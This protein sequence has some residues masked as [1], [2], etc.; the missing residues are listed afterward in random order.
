MFQIQGRNPLRSVHDPKTVAIIQARMGSTRLPGKV[1]TEINGQPMLSHV[2]NRVARANLVDEVVAAVPHTSRDKSLVQYCEQNEINV[3]AGSETDVLSRYIKAAT[4]SDAE[5]VVRITADCPLVDPALIDETISVLNR[6]PDVEYASNFWP[7]RNYP[8][9]LDTEVLTVEALLKVDRLSSA[10]NHREHV[11]LG[12][13][14]QPH[15]FKI[16][17]NFSVKDFGHLRWT[18]DTEADLQLVREI[19]RHFGER[20]FGWQDI[21][22]AYREFPHWNSINQHISQKAA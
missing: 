9:G 2:V 12:I 19:Y 1:L 20:E 6:I 16:G 15:L 14:Q 21:V 17:A 8:R 3:I 18:V 7:H 4:Q 11:T 22:Q 10:T 13:Y 5:R